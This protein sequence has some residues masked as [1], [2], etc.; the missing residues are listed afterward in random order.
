M[1]EILE[2]PG[3]TLLEGNAGPPAQDPSRLRDGEQ[4]SIKLPRARRFVPGGAPASR[5]LS[6]K[7]VELDHRRLTPRPDIDD[8]IAAFSKR[9]QIRLGHVAGKNKIPRLAAVPEYKSLFVGQ[10][11]LRE[12]RH[13]AGF[14]VR[15]LSRAVNVGVTKNGVSET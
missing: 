9:A 12:N 3:E 14:P 13:H 1:G 8:L 6:H 7:F 5:Q 15:V 11:T 4:A 2:C 10:E